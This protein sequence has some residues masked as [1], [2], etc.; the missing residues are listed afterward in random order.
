M[1]A[2]RSHFRA[3]DLDVSG[4][5]GSGGM[6]SWQAKSIPTCG[7]RFHLVLSCHGDSCV[8]PVTDDSLSL[9]F[10]DHESGLSLLYIQRWNCFLA[11]EVDSDLQCQ[12]VSGGSCHDTGQWSK[13]QM[14]ACRSHIFGPRIWTFLVLYSKMELFLGKRSGFQESYKVFIWC[15]VPLQFQQAETMPISLSLYLPRREYSVSRVHDAS[16]EWVWGK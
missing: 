14:T 8:E 4:S 2:R 13:K 9:T 15:L 5:Y 12:V 7:A 6:V 3:T 11:S 10:S 1:T 16:I